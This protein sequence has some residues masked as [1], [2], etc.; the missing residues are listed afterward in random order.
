MQSL[1]L[2][3]PLRTIRF[4][5]SF[6]VLAALLCMA[7]VSAEAQ[8]YSEQPIYSFN[9]GANGN[10]PIGG[11]VQGSDGNFYGTTDEGGS[12]TAC[13]GFGCG[14]IF[15]VTPSGTFTLLYTFKD[16]GDGAAPYAAPIEGSDGNF[17][18][19][20]YGSGSPATDAGSVYQITPSGTFHVLYAF[21]GGANGGQ[22][23]AQLVL[24]SD[25][26]LYGTTSSGGNVTGNCA[27]T[28]GC[29]TIFKVTPAGAFSTI[30]TF[31][32]GND[33]GVPLGGLVEDGAGDLY[34]TTSVDGA[35]GYG[36]VFKVTTTGTLTPVYGFCALTSCTDGEAPSS[37]LW[38]GTNGDLYGSTTKGGSNG[39]GSV[40]QLTTAGTLTTIGNF[41]T[42]YGCNDG[43]ETN[44]VF[45][46]SD[47]KYYGS[48]L[49]GGSN[50]E[51]SVY[52]VT[53]AGVV[54]PL[55]SFV[56]GTDAGHPY[57]APLQGGDGNFYGTSAG[58]G[59][60]GYG[61]VWQMAATSPSL[62]GPVQLT[63]SSSSIALKSSVTLDWKVVNGFSTTMQQ[64]YAAVQGGATTAG[65]W[66]GKQ[67]G[68]A[69][70]GGYSGSA[71]L[72][73]TAA[74]TFVYALTCGGIESG[75]ATLTVTNGSKLASSTTF[76][77]SPNPATVGQ[78]VSLKATVTG[79]GATPTGNVS[80]VFD[81]ITLG[82]AA[83]NG[84]GV[85]TLAASSNGQVPGPYAITAEYAG[86]SAYSASNS[87]PVTVT[88][89]K[90]ATTTTLA[91]SP[92]SVDPPGT[93][94]LTATV[95]RTT[96]AG[97]PTGTVTFYYTTIALGSAKV[98]G[99]GVATFAASS[100]GIPAGKYGITA[101]YAGDGSDAASTS[102]VTSVT[103]Q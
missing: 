40:F 85:A 46:G 97:K 94:T 31:T 24:G 103:V 10:S 66:S 90:A 37:T 96:G 82:S 83:L 73:P 79:S 47:G 74:G 34:G 16:T 67:T 101:K 70:S 48:T 80:F 54:T 86:N 72:T 5:Q 77:A 60:N 32:G 23:Q 11:V 4:K 52:S 20:T 61:T 44:G 33:G 27:T 100:A 45:L 28:A 6:G 59:T 81:G 1:S 69:G 39:S 51:G 55:I 102:T 12:A 91:A 65:A 89:N 99:N 30:Y 87:T 18:G 9:A 41:C 26:N 25:G 57:D 56:G 53:T 8:T 42:Q 50:S 35:N 78:T 49:F 43:S 17:Y 88:L 84:S 98:N 62:P 21:N 75:Y 76:T 71:V 64:C 29:G 7:G 3:R 36:T 22:P 68:T 63:L 95:T 14:T 13:G 92:T 93:V 38:V 15:K 2:S 19:T 58:G